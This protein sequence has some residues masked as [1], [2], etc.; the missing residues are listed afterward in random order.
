MQTMATKYPITINIHKAKQMGV[1][2]NLIAKQDNHHRDRALASLDVVDWWIEKAPLPNKEQ[3]AV[4]DTL[5]KLPRRDVKNYFDANWASGTLTFAPVLL[6]KQV[7][8]TRAPLVNIPKQLQ[9]SVV[10]QTLLP[11]FMIKYEAS[12]PEFERIVKDLISS[13]LSTKM[14]FMQQIRVVLQHL[15]NRPRMQPISS[16]MSEDSNQ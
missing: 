3:L 16:G 5:Y 15:D 13:T 9:E 4:I 1:P 11:D 6:S 12:C 14:S 2:F 10:L 8:S 7:V